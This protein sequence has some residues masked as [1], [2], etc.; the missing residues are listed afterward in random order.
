[1]NSF[2]AARACLPDT[3]TALPKG[4]LPVLPDGGP[5]TETKADPS[6]KVE[7]E[8]RAG[9]CCLPL[10]GTGHIELTRSSGPDTISF[11]LGTG[12]SSPCVPPWQSPWRERKRHCPQGTGNV[13]RCLLPPPPA[14]ALTQLSTPGADTDWDENCARRMG[15]THVGSRHWS[16][17]VWERRRRALTWELLC[18]T[19]CVALYVCP[20]LS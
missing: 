4:K 6:T 16:G 17:L 8:A 20:G 15:H 2:R 13:A 12:S 5:L 1:M 3:F 10:V 11:L 14:P 19:C 18:L 9:S 7:E